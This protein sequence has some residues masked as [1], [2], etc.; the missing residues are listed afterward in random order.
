MGIDWVRHAMN[1]NDFVTSQSASQYLGT[2]ASTQA[3]GGLSA[4]AQAG[5]KKADQRIQA[6]VDTTSAQLSSFGK[7][8]SAVSSAQIAA[9]ALGSLGSTS[10]AVAQKSAASNFTSAFNAALGAAKTTAALPGDTASA[11]SASRT[12]R[13]LLR[14]VHTDTATVDSLKKIGLSVNT[15]G[16][17]VLDGKQFDAAQ[18]ADPAGVRAT[19]NK[20]GQQVFN[21]TAQELASNGNVG[22]TLSSLNQRSGILKSQQSTLN[23]LAQTAAPAQS[24]TGFSPWNWGIAA[25]QNS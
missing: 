7:L 9:H 25:Y 3:A 8:Q 13:D 20:L 6:Q 24:S 5:L 15:G 17:L 14:V 18:K 23:T 10:T 4:A 19:L 16:N 1:I 22:L 2:G 21:A 12:S 11:Q